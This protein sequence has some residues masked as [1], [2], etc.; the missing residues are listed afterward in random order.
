MEKTCISQNGV[1]HSAI[2]QWQYT[3]VMYTTQEVI[4][5]ARSH[6]SREGEGNQSSDHHDKV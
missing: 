1:K 4:N 5:Y 6:D 3:L 2:L